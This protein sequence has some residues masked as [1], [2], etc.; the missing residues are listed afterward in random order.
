[1]NKAIVATTDSERAR[2]R[3]LKELQSRHD[4]AK[5]TDLAISYQS[6]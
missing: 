1:M 3:D 5:F 4:N 6:N 2:Q